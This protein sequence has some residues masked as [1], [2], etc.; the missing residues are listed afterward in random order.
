MNHHLP[1]MLSALLIALPGNAEEP[2]N[3]LYRCRGSDGVTSFQQ[4]P[5]SKEQ[6]DA[7]RI[8]YDPVE[9]PARA[10]APAAAPPVGPAAST[11]ASGSSSAAPTAQGESPVS[12][13]AAPDGAP[14]DLRSRVEEG[15]SDAVECLRP[16]SSTYVRSGECERSMIGGE[17]LEGYVIDAESG[18]R[19]WI[20]TVT[21]Q[22]EISDPARALG[23]LEACE[24]ARL[25]IEQIRAGKSL[26]GAFLRD[27]ERVRD[28]HCD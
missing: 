15:P 24:L 13:S 2:S 1:W 8:L 23:R 12:D 25:H 28:R 3:A 7:G 6:V 10:A 16:D 27:A 19:V 4:K 11:A 18:Q 22:R 21:Q 26:G 5:C 9:R 14:P 20:E 17:T